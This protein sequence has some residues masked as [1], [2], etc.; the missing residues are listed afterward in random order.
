MSDWDFLH[1]MHNDGYSQKDIADAAACGYSPSE[2]L[3]SEDKHEEEENPAFAWSDEQVE[4]AMAFGYTANPEL[5]PN[6]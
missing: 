2:R 1:D 3:I 4:E 6:K 5:K